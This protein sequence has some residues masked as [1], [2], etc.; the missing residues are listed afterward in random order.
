MTKTKIKTIAE[1]TKEAVIAALKET[2]G[3]VRPAALLLGVSKTTVYRM[4]GAYDIEEK[5]FLTDDD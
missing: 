1:A 3:A 5:D 2:K 4:I